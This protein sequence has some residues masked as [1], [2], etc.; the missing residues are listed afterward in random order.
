MSLF[1]VSLAGMLEMIV[2]RPVETICTR[3]APLPAEPVAAETAQTPQ[4]LPRNTRAR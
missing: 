3:L 2:A 1:L 4:C